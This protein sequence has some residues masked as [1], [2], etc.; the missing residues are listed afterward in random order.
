MREIELLVT[1]GVSHIAVNV[2]T[3]DEFHRSMDEVVP[4]IRR[5]L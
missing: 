4:E 5:L 2:D 1:H 3:M